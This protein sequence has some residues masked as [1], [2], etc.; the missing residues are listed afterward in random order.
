MKTIYS[1]NWVDEPYTADDRWHLTYADAVGVIRAPS[2]RGAP[3]V[4]FP[5]VSSREPR[6][7]SPDHL[8]GGFHVW[9]RG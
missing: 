2:V 1:P 4:L 8:M 9:G 3:R 7:Y 6:T 5:D